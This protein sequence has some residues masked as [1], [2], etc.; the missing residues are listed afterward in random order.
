[1]V[2]YTVWELS[3]S[4]S[5]ISGILSRFISTFHPLIGLH[6]LLLSLSC[7]FCPWQS[8]VYVAA[9]SHYLNDIVAHLSRPVYDSVSE[10]SGCVTGDYMGVRREG[11]DILF[12][13]GTL[14]F[15]QYV[16]NHER[17][18]PLSGLRSPNTKWWLQLNAGW[19]S[20]LSGNAN[21]K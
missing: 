17:N 21:Q 12:L 6:L 15:V 16:S 2:V 9:L 5:T 14:V 19:V 10:V 8:T 7:L 3:S 11:E 1:M 20:F 18:R 4:A 13:P